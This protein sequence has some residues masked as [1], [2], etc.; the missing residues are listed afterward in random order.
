MRFAYRFNRRT[1]SSDGTVPCNA[2]DSRRSTVSS[3]AGRDVCSRAIAA[4]GK[5]LVDFAHGPLPSASSDSCGI[6][7]IGV[8]RAGRGAHHKHHQTGGHGERCN[9]KLKRA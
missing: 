5:E 1:S 3:S 2:S 9:H 8:F 4:F 7:G 6:G